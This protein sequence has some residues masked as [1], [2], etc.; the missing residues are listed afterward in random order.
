MLRS[1]TPNS[2]SKKSSFSPFSFFFQNVQPRSLKL[3]P[4]FL[5]QRN[6]NAIDA[7]TA[8][9]T[10]TTTPTTIL[11]VSLKPLALP[12]ELR[13]DADGDADAAVVTNDVW[14]TMS[15]R[16]LATELK[17]RVVIPD[18]L[19]SVEAECVS[20]VRGASVCVSSS[21]AVSEGSVFWF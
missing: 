12:L 5:I 17:V 6:T 3:L 8:P 16:P 4:R 18:A 1:R 2:P 15:V 11:F 14:V 20:V 10:P 21:A 13:E 19:E 9:P 7:K